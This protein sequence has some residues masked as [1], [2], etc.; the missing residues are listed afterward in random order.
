MDSTCNNRV[1]SS[2]SETAC[3]SDTACL[4]GIGGLDVPSHLSLRIPLSRH[5][6]FWTLAAVGCAT[7]LVTKQWAFSAPSL[8]GGSVWWLWKGHAGFQQSLNE[9]ALFG[10][11][12]GQVGWFAIFSLVAL[13]AIPVWLFCFGA[14]RDCWLMIT[15]GC[16]VGGI[17]GNL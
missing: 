14:A 3:S 16:I 4:G 10:L 17:L 8:R 15:L 11:G 6:L 7:D 12:Q 9:G 1:A 13:F 5:L 2:S